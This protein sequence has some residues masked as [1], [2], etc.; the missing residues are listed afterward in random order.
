LSG[1]SSAPFY[2][3]R[4]GR[5]ESTNDL[6]RARAEAGAPD[7]TLIVAAEQTKGRGRHGRPWHSPPGNFYSS[8]LLRPDMMLADVASLSLVIGLVALEAVEAVVG[9]EL[10]LAL[11]WPNDLLLGEAKL[12][13]IL[14]EGAAGPDGR[15][16]WVVAGLGVNL[17]ARP[18]SAA[19]R[20]ISLAEAGLEVTPDA[21][22]EAYLAALGRRLPAWREGGFAALR[23]DWLRRAV[24]LGRAIV[25]RSGEEVHRGRLADIGL[26]GSI[27]VESPA[28][29][30]T[31]HGAGELFFAGALSA[32]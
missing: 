27:L 12:A 32:A 10:D 22:L 8:L 1:D 20:T 7:G 30:L 5:V 26:D 16:A 19:Y 6:A 2:V 28:G 17:R 21:F 24:G 25:L 11:K 29:C 31:R 13:G 23:D 3:E 14:L 9:E 18:P 15:C 4:H